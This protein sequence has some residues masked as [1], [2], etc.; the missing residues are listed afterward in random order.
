[1]IA[2]PLKHPRRR[3]NDLLNVCHGWPL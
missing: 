3:R 1:V 2:L